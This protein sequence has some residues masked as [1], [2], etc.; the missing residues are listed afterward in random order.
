MKIDAY[1]GATE[2]VCSKHSSLSG[3]I[4]HDLLIVKG[5]CSQIEFR[6]EL[7]RVGTYGSVTSEGGK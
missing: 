2:A 3:A 1:R 7:N 4:L 6:I 5:E